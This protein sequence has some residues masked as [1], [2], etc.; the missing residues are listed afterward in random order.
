MS[1]LSDYWVFVSDTPF[2][3]SEVPR[4]SPSRAGVWSSRQTSA[5]NPYAIIPVNAS[6]RYV[7][8]QLNSRNFLHMAKVQVTSARR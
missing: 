2:A 4:R 1:R 7:R 5:P 8:I 3:A 6:G